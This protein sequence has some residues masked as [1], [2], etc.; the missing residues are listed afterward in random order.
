MANSLSLVA[1]AT[2]VFSC[3]SNG[4]L[5]P[6]TRVPGNCVQRNAESR[7]DGRRVGGRFSAA[8]SAREMM[9]YRRLSASRRSA[10][11][12]RIAFYLGL[13]SQALAC[14]CSATSRLTFPTCHV[15]TSV[16]NRHFI[17]MKSDFPLN[18]SGYCHPELENFTPSQQTKQ[19]SKTA[20]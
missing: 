6:G 2:V 19:T 20:P 10:T 14:R 13:A 16:C 11:H 9:A 17:A 4:M 3:G 1:V 7:S 8:N 12:S 18:P 15:G 5:K